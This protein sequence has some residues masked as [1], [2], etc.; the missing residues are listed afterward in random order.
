VIARRM[1]MVDVTEKINLC[2]DPADDKFLELAVSG[3]AA[4]L[5]T[6]DVDLLMLHPW[7]DVQILTPR[8]FIADVPP[9]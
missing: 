2:R 5:L 4:I 6:G 3:Q 7:R 1:T 8:Q 9:G